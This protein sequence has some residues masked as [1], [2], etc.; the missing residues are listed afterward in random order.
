M[1]DM[2]QLGLEQYNSDGSTWSK[3]QRHAAELSAD[4]V[5]EVVNTLAGEYWL[6]PYQVATLRLW[7][8]GLIRALTPMILELEKNGNL[9]YSLFRTLVEF[10]KEQRRMGSF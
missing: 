7:Y 2:K 3:K 6:E 10:F 1:Q 9:E 5:D 4:V 8:Q